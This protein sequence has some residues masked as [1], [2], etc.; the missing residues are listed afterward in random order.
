[1][2]STQLSGTDVQ[3]A[4]EGQLI[5]LPTVSRFDRVT[6]R[7]LV[8]LGVYV[9]A[10]TAIGM[11]LTIA[12]VIFGGAALVHGFSTANT[13]GAGTSTSQPAVPVPNVPAVPDPCPNGF[14]PTVPQCSGQAGE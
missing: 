11:T 13:G 4:P 3:F 10:L 5:E 2:T 6:R 9:L 12:A 14:D 7:V 1:M 8:L